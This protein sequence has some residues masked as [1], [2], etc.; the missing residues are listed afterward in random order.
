MT[1]FSLAMAWGW[2]RFKGGGQ[3]SDLV[4]LKMENQHQRWKMFL[5]LVGDYKA[6]RLLAS[7]KEAERRQEGK[8]LRRLNALTSGWGLAPSGSGAFVR[9]LD[10]SR[11]TDEHRP[12]SLGW[13]HK[14]GW[15]PPQV[16][17][18]D[19]IP[20]L[21]PRMFGRLA[22]LPL[23]RVLRSPVFKAYGGFTGVNFDEVAEPLAS[24]GSLNK[25]FTRYA[26][27]IIRSNMLLDALLCNY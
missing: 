14:M 20:F 12:P 7:E 8:D 22:S 24:Y 11:P 18:W 17:R 3:Q 16:L 15:K 5:E 1:M 23:P 9:N 19:I 2:I 25:F 26:I 21:G 10:N 13:R 27:A 4:T 6:V